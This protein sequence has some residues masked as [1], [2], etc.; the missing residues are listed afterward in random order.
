MVGSFVPVVIMSLLKLSG[1][2]DILWYKVFITELITTVIG[3]SIL[4][5]ATATLYF[6]ETKGRE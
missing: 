6:Y 2:E 1:R 3:V 5:A 4:I